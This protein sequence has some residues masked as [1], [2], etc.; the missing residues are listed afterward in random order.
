M[1]SL[2]E[3]PGIGYVFIHLTFERSGLGLRR[4]KH[5]AEFS[6]STPR[7]REFALLTIL[8][9]RAGALILEAV[10]NSLTE[11]EKKCLL[12]VENKRKQ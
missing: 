5:F 1:C 9:L 4:K 12:V 11:H 8:F 2:K 6:R 10:N 3:R 7:G